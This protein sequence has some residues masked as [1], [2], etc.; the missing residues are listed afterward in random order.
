MG[1]G[2]ESAERSAPLLPRRCAGPSSGSRQG[3]AMKDSNTIRRDF[4]RDGFSI[5]R[6]VFEQSQV[7]EL[8]KLFSL[9]EKAGVARSRQILYT[10]QEPPLGRPGMDRLMDQWLYPSAHLG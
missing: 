9:L 10:H 1:I 2:R 5:F 6:G 4:A 8:R 3:L 7:D